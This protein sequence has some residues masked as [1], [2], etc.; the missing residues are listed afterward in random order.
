MS[1]KHNSQEENK[2]LVLSRKVGESIYIDDNIKITILN[3]SSSRTR[4]GFDAPDDVHIVRS[5]LYD[6]SAVPS[7]SR[8][9]EETNVGQNRRH[10]LP[11]R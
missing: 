3:I 7:E 10:P 9:I 8:S 5:E 1:L 2:M 4:I 6:R 11:P